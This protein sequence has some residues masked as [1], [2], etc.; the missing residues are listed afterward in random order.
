MDKTAAIGVLGEFCSC[1][2]MLGIRD[3]RIFL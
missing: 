3:P 1:L 2:K